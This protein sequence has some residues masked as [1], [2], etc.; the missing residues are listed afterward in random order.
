MT[1]PATV[2]PDRRAITVISVLGAGAAVSVILGVYG[3]VHDPTGR[4]IFTLGFSEM[5]SMKIWLCTLAFALGVTQVIS[6]LWM[7]DRLPGVTTKP[8]WLPWVHRW[9]GTLAFV[10]TVPVAYHCLWSIGYGNQLAD[11]SENVR[12]AVHSFFGCLFYGIFTVKMLAL[13]SKRLPGWTLPVAGGRLFS[14]LTVLWFTSALW[15]FRY[16]DFP[17]F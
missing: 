10:A 5:S 1:A 12:R 13:R 15:W 8:S 2:A 16:V 6:A 7:Y 11:D 14:T 9:T 3:H 17:A 4:N